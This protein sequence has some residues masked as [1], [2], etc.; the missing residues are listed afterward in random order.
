ME[1]Y[2]CVRTAHDLAIALVRPGVK[3]ADIDRAARDHIE[4][5]GFGKYFGHGTGHGTGLN[6]HEGPNISPKSKD[7]LQEGM[8]FTVEPG[9]YV[10]GFGGVRIEDMVHVTQDGAVLLT[11]A[12]QG[13]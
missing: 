3:A 13:R 6:I 5:A 7:V 2:D 8:V 1:I 12:S 10:P 9:I 4:R 11:E